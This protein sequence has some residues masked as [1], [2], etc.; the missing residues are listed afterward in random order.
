MK[1]PRSLRNLEGVHDDLVKI[2][3]KAFEMAE[4]DGRLIFKITE[5]VRTA[6]RQKELVEQK[7]SFTN[8]SRHIPENNACGL[9]C[10]VDVVAIVNGTVS[11]EMK[12][13]AVI[14]SF[15][16]LAAFSL[17]LEVEWGGD[18]KTFKDGPHFQLPVSKYPKSK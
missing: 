15:F 11:W 6:E 18:W 12:H 4:E 8:S 5:G 17:D 2:V 1:D 7:K 16:K 9:S 3:K 14:A 13:Y 10:A